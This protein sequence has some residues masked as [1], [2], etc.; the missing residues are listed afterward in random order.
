MWRKQARSGIAVPFFV[1]LPGASKLIATHRAISLLGFTLRSAHGKLMCKHQQCHHPVSNPRRRATRP[2]ERHSSTQAQRMTQPDKAW[3]VPWLVWKCSRLQSQTL[4]PASAYTLAAEAS[5]DTTALAVAAAAA[6]I[7][8]QTSLPLL[9]CSSQL[10][11][12]PLHPHRSCGLKCPRQTRQAKLQQAHNHHSQRSH[13]LS[14]HHCHQ[15]QMVKQCYRFQSG[16]ADACR[17]HV[18]RDATGTDAAADK[19]DVAVLLAASGRLAMPACWAVLRGSSLQLCPG[20]A[21]SEVCLS[22]WH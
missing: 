1:T 18:R 8:A 21:L 12:F 6:S 5:A 10:A 9:L 3:L 20:A 2:Q 16:H 13:G 19:A 7:A 22:R 15:Q 4:I 14:I 11:M 17:D